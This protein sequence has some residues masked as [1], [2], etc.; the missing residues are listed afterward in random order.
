[1]TQIL[2]WWINIYV[3]RLQTLSWKNVLSDIVEFRDPI[4]TAQYVETE[5]I[6]NQAALIY[7]ENPDE[8]INL[9]SN[10]AY[11]RANQW[12]NSWKELGNELF[13]KYWYIYGTN[14]SNL[15]EW[16]LEGIGYTEPVR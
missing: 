10:Y 5:E 1:L 8:A 11:S 16:W 15:P 4:M 3:Q 12:F 9:I 2:A 7:K 13:S 6:Q 14:A